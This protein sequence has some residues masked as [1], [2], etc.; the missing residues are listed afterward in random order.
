[1]RQR[2][3]D[4]AMMMRGNTRRRRRG[5]TTPTRRGKDDDEEARQQGQYTSELWG[6]IA[7]SLLPY[8]CKEFFYVLDIHKE[9]YPP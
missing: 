9:G 6:L 3:G 8:Y 2:K 7:A 1:M 5:D 4:T